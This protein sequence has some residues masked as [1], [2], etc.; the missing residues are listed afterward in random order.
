MLHIYWRDGRHTAE[1]LDS[2]CWE[3]NGNMVVWFLYD[4]DILNDITN[5]FYV[6]EN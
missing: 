2:E 3:K 6:Y 1:E 4:H 5:I